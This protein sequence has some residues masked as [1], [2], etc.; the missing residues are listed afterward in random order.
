MY[1]TEIVVNT[2]QTAVEIITDDNA[3]NYRYFNLQ[4]AEV[5]PQN[6]VPGIYIRQSGNKAEKII[7]R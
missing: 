4:G 6:L 5:N 1:S 3:A 7:I 2:T